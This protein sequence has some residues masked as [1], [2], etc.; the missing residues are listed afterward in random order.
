[1]TH[2]S[3]PEPNANPH[4]PPSGYT[5]VDNTIFDHIMPTLSGNGLKILLVALRQTWGW[6]DDRSPTGRKRSDQ[7]S[8]SQFM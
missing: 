3:N 1:M 6:K 4:A 7:I 5:P 8:Y 2:T